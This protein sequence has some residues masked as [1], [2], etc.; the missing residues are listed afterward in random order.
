MVPVPV[1][2]GCPVAD[3][4]AVVL[5]SSVAWSVGGG[6]NIYPGRALSAEYP[7]RA[8]QA[9]RTTPKHEPEEPRQTQ[10]LSAPPPPP[11]PPPQARRYVINRRFGLLAFAARVGYF[12]SACVHMCLPLVF[13]LGRA[14]RSRN[15]K[16]TPAVLWRKTACLF[17]LTPKPYKH[18][19]EAVLQTQI[20]VFP[21]PDIIYKT[22]RDIR[23]SVA[24]LC[25]VLL[26]APSGRISDLSRVL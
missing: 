14:L 25:F 11:L 19:R 16:Q 4:A 7:K 13:L 5:C 18:L 8:R 23:T 21:C 3:K 20:S 12:Q 2:Y 24:L 22:A 15:C 17:N 10:S 6:V 26:M 9:P 1:R